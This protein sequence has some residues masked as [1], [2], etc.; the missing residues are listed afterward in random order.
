MSKSEITGA[1]EHLSKHDKV[2]STIIKNIGIIN[3]TQHKKYYNLLLGSII[4]QQLSTYAAA[5]IHKRFMNFYKNNP[6]PEFILKTDDSALRLLGLSNAKVKY[7]KDLS[8]KIL[9][10]ELKLKGFAKKSDDEIIAELTKVKGIGV[11][12]SHMFLMFTL[13][14]LNV[15]PFGDLGIRKSIMVNYRL[16]KMPDEK[17]IRLIAKQNNWHPYCS[18]A[19]LYLWR[20]LDTKDES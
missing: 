8:V 7:V 17:K 14:R 16:K 11:W 3:L 13:G 18:I 9:S 10:G 1:I 6:R 5:S 2:L 15:L 12:T 4:S 20:S 19:S